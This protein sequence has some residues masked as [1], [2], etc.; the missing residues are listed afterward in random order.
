MRRCRLPCLFALCISVTFTTPALA[1]DAPRPNVLFIVTD[2]QHAGMMSCEG[3]PDLKTPAM[4][5]LAASGLRFHRAYAANPVC[6]PSRFAMRTGHMPSEI[7]MRHNNT[8]LSVPAGMLERSLGTLMRKAGY[9]CAH[10]GKVH[11]PGDLHRQ[12]FHGGYRRLGGGD[13]RDDLAVACAEFIKTPRERPFFL[14]AS[15][16]NP[17]DVCYMAINDFARQNDKPV[18][19]NRDSWTCER[20][21]DVARGSGDLRQFVDAH[22]PALPSNFEP[23]R[24]EPTCIT[25]HYTQV[26]PFRRYAREHW[27]DDQWRLHRWLYCRL[28]ERVD[29]Q[30]GRV[31]DALGEA[32]IEENTL[33]VFTSDHGDM[34]GAHR[35]EHKSI[36]YEEAA[37]VPMILSF[38]GRIEPGRIDASHL[39]STGLDILPTICDFAGVDVPEGLR[40]ASLRPIAEGRPAE[41]WR[42]HVVVESQNGRMV[43]TERFKYTVYDCGEHRE[44]LVDLARDPGEMDNLA[45]RAEYREELN[46]HRRLL[47]KWCRQQNDSIA[48]AYLVEPR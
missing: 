6:V 41:R 14:V 3:N 16:I 18:V 35:L 2:Q 9:D 36:L 20:F 13:A 22:C 8:R 47:L 45:T 33:V 1:E 37:R 15:F 43:R 26:R 34:D 21:L 17:H 42:N 48:L 29:A 39:V 28:T 4:D 30:V 24:D 44:T 23:P 12:M 25:T 11:V 27:S 31:L 5:A 38:A 10:G 32:G 19:G 46:R 7:G 40:G